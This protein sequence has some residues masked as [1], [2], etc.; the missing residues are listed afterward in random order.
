MSGLPMNRTLLLALAAAV[1]L[2]AAALAPAF[3][4]EETPIL[5]GYWE[6]HYS[7]FF[8]SPKPNRTC[9]TP[10]K[11]EEYMSGPSN[12]HYT[13]TYS[14]REIGGGHVR[15]RG[16]CVDKH[17]KRSRIALEG[18]YTPTHFSVNW[19]FNYKLGAVG[20]PLSGSLE[21]RRISATCPAGTKKD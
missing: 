11:V 4:Q 17:G 2:A 10:N 15:M 14:E 3:A 13:C 19:H 5:P 1:P 20:L 18:T 7:V 9:V 6:S 16:E 21:A 12:R 8:V